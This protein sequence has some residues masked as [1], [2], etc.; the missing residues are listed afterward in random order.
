MASEMFWDAVIDTSTT[1]SVVC[2]LCDRTHFV[3]SFDDGVGDYEEGGFMALHLRVEDMP[4]KYVETTD[5]VIRWGTL[6]GKTFVWQ[7][8]CGKADRY[9]EFLINSR[10]VIL[11]Y[12]GRRAKSLTE[13][14]AGEQA[15]LAA[16]ESETPTAENIQCPTCGARFDVYG[17]GPEQVVK[18]PGCGGISDYESEK[19][20]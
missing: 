9:E 17:S 3:A 6:D 19:G 14:A 18:C 15:D 2:G 7:C 1:T 20:G 10:G 16:I 4:D 12:L 8:P 5:D 11:N 13:N